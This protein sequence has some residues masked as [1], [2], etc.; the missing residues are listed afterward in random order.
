LLKE[1]LNS[2]NFAIFFDNYHK[3]EK[4]LNPLLK[5][6]VS[7]TSSKI[8][9]ITR[10]EPEFYNVVDERENRVTKIKVDA[11]GFA[12][13]KLMLEARGIE[14]TEETKEEIHDRLHGHPQYLRNT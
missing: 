8:I 7:I 13:T 9:I 2:D 10:E 14:T 4:E 1:E 3:A 5:Q 6:L 11:W 12:N